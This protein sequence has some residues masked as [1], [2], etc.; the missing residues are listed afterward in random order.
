MDPAGFPWS[1]FLYP[2]DEDNTIATSQG[3]YD[4]LGSK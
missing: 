4:V 2:D 3:L 1:S